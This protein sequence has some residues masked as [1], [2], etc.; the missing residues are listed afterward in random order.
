MILPKIGELK[1]VIDVLNVTAPYN[2]EM[3]GTVVSVAAASLW[4]KIEP[5]GG[6]VDIESQQVQTCAQEYRVW[7]RYCE[8]L[9]PWQQI[10]WG[11]KQLAIMGPIENMQ[12]R[13]LL[14][15]AQERTSRSV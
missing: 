4:A 3:K 6:S 11:A 15:H 8:G 14:I 12:N 5:L 13:F 10:R 9:N 7:I 2:M 1:E